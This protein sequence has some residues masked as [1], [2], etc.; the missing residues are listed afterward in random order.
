MLGGVKLAI[1]LAA[2]MH[3]CVDALCM[4]CLSISTNNLSCYFVYNVIAFLT[5]PITGLIADKVKNKYSILY[6]SVLFFALSVLISALASCNTIVVAILL[7]I[8]NS[9]FHVWGGRG[10]AVATQNDIRALGIFVSPGVLGL[11]VGAIYASWYLLYILLMLFGILTTIHSCFA[12][13]VES[14]SQLDNN[15]KLYVFFVIL[16]LIVFVILRSF[17]A[18]EFSTTLEKD[19]GILILISA[20]IAALGK[21]L[22]GFFATFSQKYILTFIVFIIVTLFCFI[23]RNNLFI[24]T[25]IGLF[26]VNCTMPFTLY[27]AQNLLPKRE[28]FAFGL[29]AAALMP[30]YII[31]NIALL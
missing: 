21:G 25:Y 16:S 24:S 29:L 31:V 10:V 28:G 22:G 19:S 1:M 6:L 11:A 3:F 4:C 18:G 5:Q 7:G 12:N 27:W 2:L 26:A 13:F 8:G 23:E 15:K 17:G 9:L 14:Q 20:F 30:P